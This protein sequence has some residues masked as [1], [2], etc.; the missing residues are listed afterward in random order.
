MVFSHLYSSAL[1]QELGTD[2]STRLFTDARR[3]T[4]INNGVLAFTDLTECAVRQSTVTCSNGVAEYNLL[5]TVSVPSGDYLRL[6]K[7]GPEYHH[8][9]SGGTSS[10]ST[11][12]IAGPDQFPRREIPWL[13]QYEPGWRATTSGTPQ[14]YY[15]RVDGGRRFF[16][17]VPPPS[18]TS[19]QTGQ[20]VL[21]YLAKPAEMTSDTDVPFTFGSTTRT[22]LEPYHPAAVHYAAHELEKLRLNEQASQSQMQQFLGYVERYLKA[23]QPKGGQQVKLGRNYFSEVRGRRGAD[24]E[25]P[26]PYP[27]RQ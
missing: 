11:T 21:P 20:I 25:Q 14:A 17:L 6:A 15:E 26:V 13:N 19:S 4:A 5:S 9:T 18:I 3:K 16:G 1:T 2:D 22:D 8:V 24:I 7:Q 10:N 23:Q 12:F 27:W